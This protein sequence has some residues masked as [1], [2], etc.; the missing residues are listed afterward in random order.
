MSLSIG[1]K[2]KN[3]F[4]SGFGDTDS[5]GHHGRVEA[6]GIDW[7]VVRDV[8]IDKPIFVGIPPDKFYEN[9]I[10]LKWNVEEDS[11]NRG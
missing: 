3:C 8:E 7:V 9:A 4:M 10:T 6:I 2:I 5:S 1:F 11:F